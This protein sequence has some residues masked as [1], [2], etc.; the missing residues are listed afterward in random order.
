MNDKVGIF[1]DKK[2][3][4]EALEEVLALK[5]RMKKV[6]AKYNAEGM[7]PEL[8]G[9][10]ELRANLDLAEVIV[11]GALGREESRGS[12]FRTDFETRDDQKF[13][14]HTLGRYKDGLA[15]MS[16]SPVTLGIWEPK[17]RKY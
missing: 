16:T 15:E 8:Q 12:H 1:R 11:R 10:L 13:L 17:E 5:E 7:N 2:L 9:N 3:L 6:G 4:S 14:H